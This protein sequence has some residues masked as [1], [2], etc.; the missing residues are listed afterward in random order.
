MAN[1]IQLRL[2]KREVEDFNYSHPLL[3]FDVES[4]MGA[5][6]QLTT[7]E[8]KKELLQTIRK[9]LTL[10]RGY[11][12]YSEYQISEYNKVIFISPLKE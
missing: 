5:G 9:Y 4:L 12:K 10:P 7:E 3:E 1:K 11:L 6:F 8:D 2:G